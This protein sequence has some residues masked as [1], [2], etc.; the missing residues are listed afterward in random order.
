MR[1]PPNL[2]GRDQIRSFVVAVGNAEV[3]VQSYWM[4]DVRNPRRS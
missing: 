3:W 4:L 1:P 2:V